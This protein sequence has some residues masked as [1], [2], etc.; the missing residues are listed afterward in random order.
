M[1]LLL[2]LMV[3]LHLVIEK[4][5]RLEI[6]VSQ[7]LGALP[8]VAAFWEDLTT[9]NGGD[10]YRLINDDYVII[11]W[12]EMRVYEHGSQENTLQMILYNPENSFL[13]LLVMEK[14]KFS[15]KSLTIYLMVIILN[16]HHYMVVILQ[17][18]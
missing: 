3:G 6:I 17:L 1:K 4:W 14:L 9:N 2:V 12:N 13:P 5:L 18:A 8:M 11:Q 7:E 10:V 15:I 16:I